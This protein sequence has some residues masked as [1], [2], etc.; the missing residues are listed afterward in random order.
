MP[1]TR[2][3]AHKIRRNRLGWCQAV[4]FRHPPEP[5]ATGS[6]PVGRAS[7]RPSS[8][9]PPRT[10]SER[11]E[12][13]GRARQPSL[14]CGF[15]RTSSVS[16]GWLRH[17]T[18][19]SFVPPRRVTAGKPFD[20]RSLP[21]A[22]VPRELRRDCRQ[23]HAPRATFDREFPKD[24]TVVLEL[25]WRGMQTGPLPTPRGE[26][27]PTGRRIEVRACQIIEVSGERVKSVRHYFD[28]NTLLQQLNVPA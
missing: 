13:K 27:A 19:V 24:N 12:S 20:E 22:R 1:P 9:H 14:T 16:Y 18:C 23:D 11:S 25:T 7:S 26:I 6:N 2:E 15:L 8:K 17:Q 4:W 21:V 10:L 5:K 3:E 28:V